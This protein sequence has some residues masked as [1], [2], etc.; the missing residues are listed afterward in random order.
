M[1]QNVIYGKLTS[2]SLP[3]VCN[4]PS[5]LSIYVCNTQQAGS[6]GSSYQISKYTSKKHL[7][8]FNISHSILALQTT[9]AYQTIGNYLKIPQNFSDSSSEVYVDEMQAPKQFHFPHSTYNLLYYIVSAFLWYCITCMQKKLLAQINQIVFTVR[10][11]IRP[12]YTYSQ[13]IGGFAAIFAR[14]GQ[15]S[16]KVRPVHTMAEGCVDSYSCW[17]FL[18]LSVLL[19]LF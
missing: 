9:T 15:N 19:E 1:W 6:H 2:K 13:K 12:F 18:F 14:S 17:N 8:Q 16:K 5:F 3:L 4:L 7:F 11:R 10:Y